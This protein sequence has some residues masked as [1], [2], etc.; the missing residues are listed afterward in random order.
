MEYHYYVLCLT[1]YQYYFQCMS[2]HVLKFTTVCNSGRAT[3]I[4]DVILS[5]R[6]PPWSS[7]EYCTR[8]GPRKWHT[9]KCLTSLLVSCTLL[10][11]EVSNDVTSWTLNGCNILRYPRV[12][13][14]NWI[15]LV[16]FT[17][18]MRNMF[19]WP[20]CYMRCL[21]LKFLTGVTYQ[22]ILMATIPPPPKSRCSW[23]FSRFGHTF[24]TNG[25]T[26]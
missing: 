19:I 2:V 26:V 3:H 21:K 17:P 8:W 14:C 10:L 4:S 5:S 15:L 20:P 23:L 6:R 24:G 11:S 12:R 7:R 1:T 25:P 22:L 13:L 18:F 9:N 16:T